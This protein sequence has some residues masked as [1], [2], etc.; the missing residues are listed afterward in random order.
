VSPPASITKKALSV[1]LAET[2]KSTATP[3]INPLQSGALENQA[4]NAVVVFWRC[5][6]RPAPTCLAAISPAM[7]PGG[8]R[9]AGVEDRF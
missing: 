1:S 5:V 8:V 7:R 2:L 9:A 6:P 4:S 3:P